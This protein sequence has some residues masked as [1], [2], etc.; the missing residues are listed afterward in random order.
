MCFGLL[1]SPLQE[2]GN[3]SVTW[4]FL[5]QRRF[6]VAS[7]T[8]KI[9]FI[10]SWKLPQKYTFVPQAA[11]LHIFSKYT[12]LF[13]SFESQKMFWIFLLLSR[14]LLDLRPQALN[15]CNTH[16]ALVYLPE[17][18]D[19]TLNVQL[20]KFRNSR[21]FVVEFI[22]KSQVRLVFQKTQTFAY[23]MIRFWWLQRNRVPLSFQTIQAILWWNSLYFHMV[24]KY[25]CCEIKSLRCFALNVQINYT[26]SVYR[27]EKKSFGSAG[28]I[29]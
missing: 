5:A 2:Y 18:I 1:L 12:L 20:A 29:L 19:S 13:L 28:K 9:K 11:N 27:A 23:K 15:A 26:C 24:L 25:K 21:G 16:T 8:P 10:I 3:H 7:E 17:K 14:S 6:N 22:V 4:L